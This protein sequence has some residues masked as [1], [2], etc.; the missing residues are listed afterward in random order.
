MNWP[1]LMELAVKTNGFQKA[2]GVTSRFLNDFI[3]LVKIHNF[4]WLPEPCIS[5]VS[6][7]NTQAI[8]RRIE[9]AINE[10]NKTGSY[11]KLEYS[12]RLGLWF[13]QPWAQELLFHITEKGDLGVVVYPGNTKSQ[14]KHIFGHEPQLNT[15]IT[16]TNKVRPVSIC[17]LIK[18]TSFQRYFAG[19]WFSENDLNNV[20]FTKDNFWKHCGRKK[21]GKDW[22]GI[23]SLFNDCF[24]QSFDWKRICAWEAKII[25]S[26]RSQFDLSFGYE[27]CIYIPFL[28]LKVADQ[29]KSDLSGLT[30]LIES[31]YQAFKTIYKQ[32]FFILE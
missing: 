8:R 9:S 7:N 21:R 32:L 10:L 22:D 24:K 16:V 30:N 25:N 13:D 18:F 26:G 27:L 31:A 12:D 14:G 23:E 3:E 29:S 4:R 28:E 11:T 5:S 19:L 20:L 6:S 2:M 15:E 1:K 17:Y